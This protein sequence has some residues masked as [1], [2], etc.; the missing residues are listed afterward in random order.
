VSEVPVGVVMETG[1]YRL[2][3]TWTLVGV[4]TPSVTR[5]VTVTLPVPVGVPLIRPVDVL[6]VRPA[7]RVPENTDHV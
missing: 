6:S 2:K 3:V 7:G 5:N 1:A 4:V